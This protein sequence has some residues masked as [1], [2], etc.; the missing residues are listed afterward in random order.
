[1][2]VT[3]LLVVFFC[4][5]FLSLALIVTDKKLTV[6]EKKYKF[7]MGL[8]KILASL[9]AFKISSFLSTYLNNLNKK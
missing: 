5:R 1:M 3:I 6:A 2:L 7:T 9:T 8:S 4:L